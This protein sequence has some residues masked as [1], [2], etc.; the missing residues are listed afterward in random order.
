M[1]EGVVTNHDVQRAI[2]DHCQFFDKLNPGF[3]H[4]QPD[5][6]GN[7]EPDFFSAF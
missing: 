6:V 2:R 1:L 3:F 7:I 4:L 5:L